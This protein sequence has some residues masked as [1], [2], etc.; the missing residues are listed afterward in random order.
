MTHAST[1]SL[2]GPAPSAPPPAPPSDGP[3]GGG[4]E[5]PLSGGGIAPA[6]EDEI[7]Y[8]VSPP[9]VSWPRVLPQL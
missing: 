3:D 8:P 7:F 9:S 2:S 5:R 6:E 4:V 1:T